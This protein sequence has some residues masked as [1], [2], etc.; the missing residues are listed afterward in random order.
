[1]ARS[2]PLKR[3]PMS[4]DRMRAACLLPLQNNATIDDAQEYCLDGWTAYYNMTQEPQ[5]KDFI[6][7]LQICNEVVCLWN[8]GYI[9]RNVAPEEIAEAQ[10]GLLKTLERSRRLGSWA[11]DGTVLD[12]IRGTIY[13]WQS[14][15]SIA[16]IKAIKAV[17]IALKDMEKEN[18]DHSTEKIYRI[19]KQMVR[20]KNGIKL[21]DKET[22]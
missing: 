16:P 5:E 14:Q 11:L 1:M 15:Y 10:N 7:L 8:M 6:T 3:K 12:K 20:T 17:R 2:R 18:P 21:I 19:Q 22:A 9:P 4:Y 13:A